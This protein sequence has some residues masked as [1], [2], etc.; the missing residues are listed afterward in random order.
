[1]YFNTSI[2]TR[3]VVVGMVVVWSA[4]CT[5]IKRVT[6]YHMSLVNL[7]ATVVFVIGKSKHFA[8]FFIIF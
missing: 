4:I 1:M 7:Q 3:K 8:V 5:C 6:F 2:K